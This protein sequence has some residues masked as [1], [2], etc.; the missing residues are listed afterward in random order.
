MISYD[1]GKSKHIIPYQS[2]FYQG[3]NFTITYS[4]I[5]FGNNSDYGIALFVSA[6]EITMHMSIECLSTT[7][8]NWDGNTTLISY[9]DIE[10]GYNINSGCSSKVPEKKN[11]IIT[12]LPKSCFYERYAD[13]LDV[14]YLPNLFIGLTIQEEFV[15]E[16][17]GDI[18]ISFSSDGS[19]VGAGFEIVQK[20]VS[21]TCGPSVVK[22]PC[23]GSVYL[24]VTETINSY[25]YCSNMNCSFSIVR[26]ETCSD[27]QL[28]LEVLVIFNMFSNDSLIIKVD[29]KPSESF[30]STSVKTMSF[31]SDAKVEIDFTSGTTDAKLYPASYV[32]LQL[33]ID[34]EDNDQGSSSLSTESSSLFPESSSLSSESSTSPNGG[35]N[36]SPGL[37]S[38]L[39]VFSIILLIEKV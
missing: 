18:D 26:E 27:L 32:I 28:N 24:P 35:S 37:S 16:N 39:L 29:G 4:K 8:S 36:L 3:E 5:P 7:S 2:M 10:N 11:H 20:Y 38:I 12:L 14:S 17:A 19:V 6:V 33:F 1:S 25:S 30:N 21:C 9:L 31:P 23:K 22:V 15:V 13:R 34:A